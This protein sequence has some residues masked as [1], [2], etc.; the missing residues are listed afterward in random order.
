MS[1]KK[2]QKAPVVAA[3]V[4]D[5]TVVKPKPVV[6]VKKETPKP[7]VSVFDIEKPTKVNEL[8]EVSFL[9][10]K[11][12]INYYEKEFIKSVCHNRA[13]LDYN[14]NV[15]SYLINPRTGCPYSDLTMHFKYNKS[16][17]IEYNGRYIN[18][19][20]YLDNLE[21]HKKI[22]NY[23]EKSGFKC[24]IFKTGYNRETDR[25]SGV[26]ILVKW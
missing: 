26:M 10:F 20:K 9:E 3:K 23:Y 14:R 16:S 11:D 19:A 6:A 1:S 12:A 7:N 8:D 25:Y 15:K 4:V 5:K 17:N 2:E 21:L 13:F 24:E 18:I 22:I